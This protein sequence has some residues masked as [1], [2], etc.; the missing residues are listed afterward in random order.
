MRVVAKVEITAAE[1]LQYFFL[2]K[3][4]Q[5]GST[6]AYGRKLNSFSQVTTLEINRK[7]V[8]HFCQHDWSRKQT[9]CHWRRRGNFC[10]SVFTF[11]N[12]LWIGNHKESGVRTCFHRRCNGECWQTSFRV[13]ILVNC[14]LLVY[15]KKPKSHVQYRDYVYIQNILN[16]SGIVFLVVVFVVF[17]FPSKLPRKGR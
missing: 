16:A 9:S 10:K 11:L 7:L 8:E 14:L 4:L 13:G 1:K 3:N 12:W 2:S 17:F 5:K 6:C 15:D